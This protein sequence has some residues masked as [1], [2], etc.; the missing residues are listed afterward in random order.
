MT[1]SFG[2]FGVVLLSAYAAAAQGVPQMEIFLGYTLVRFGSSTNEPAFTS[3]GG[4]GQFAY[5]FNKWLGG[6]ADLGPCTIATYTTRTWI[7]PPRTFSS[8]RGFRFVT[9]GSV[10]TSRPCSEVCIMPL[11]M[12]SRDPSSRRRRR[13]RVSPANQ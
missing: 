6:V 3:N 5:N 4:S 2:T 8:G 1:K 7:I 10:P 9:R 13:I 11:V 12:E